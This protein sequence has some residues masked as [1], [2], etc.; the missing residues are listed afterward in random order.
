[1]TPLQE[2]VDLSRRYGEGTDWVIAG[3]GNTSVKDGESMWIKASGTTLEGIDESGFVHMDRRALAALW[4]R[5]YPADPD[6]REQRALADLLASRGDGDATARPSV[7]TLM[8]ALFPHRIVCHTH[9]ARV[10][11]ITCAR[12]GREATRSLLG[13]DT[14]WM[15]TVNPGYTLAQEL[16]DRIEA[17][18]TAHEGRWPAAVVMQNHGLV[19]AGETAEE[20]HAANR[21]IHRIVTT[22]TRRT[23]TL[24]PEERDTPPLREL[25]E[26]VTEGYREAETGYGNPSP[27]LQSTAFTNPELL[28]RAGS[29]S[30]FAPLLG[31]LTPD[32]IVYSGHRPC[33]VPLT[34]PQA[35]APSIRKAV[36]DAVRQ[37]RSREGALP[38]I[39]VVQGRGAVA[40]TTTE[41]RSTYARLLFLDALKI[42]CYAES[43][44]GVAPMPEDQVEFIRNWE[45]ERF[46]ERRSTT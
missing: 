5:P 25:A 32:H 3:G 7:E 31:A 6:R 23:P 8:H 21:R 18:R 27:M 41:K 4:E 16:R 44:G 14:A 24:A 28:R 29:R 33:F 30:S 36:V 17:W 35:P 19:V 46:R 20:V 2:I 38:K 13:S 11:G 39:I 15:P 12:D 42:A 34:A 9:P 45:V 37:F 1:M 43:F 22:A 40:V 26:A 10:N